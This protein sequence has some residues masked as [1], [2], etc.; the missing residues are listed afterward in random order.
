MTKLLLSIPTQLCCDLFLVDDGAPSGPETTA[1]SSETNL[2]L[3]RVNH[4]PSTGI[5]NDCRALLILELLCIFPDS[6]SSKIPLY[7]DN[8][9]TTM[10]FIQAKAECSLSPIL[11]NNCICPIGDNISPLNPIKGV[12]A[13]KYYVL[14]EMRVDECCNN[15]NEGIRR[16]VIKTY[17]RVSRQRRVKH[18]AP[19]WHG[20]SFCFCC[21]LEDFQMILRIFT[22]VICLDMAGHPCFLG[23]RSVKDLLPHIPMAGTSH[24]LPYAISSSLILTSSALVKVRW[25]SRRGPEFTWER[26]DSFKQ[27]YPQLFTNWASSSTTRS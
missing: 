6:W 16:K 2:L 15:R 7:I 1:H 26:E 18:V 3:F 17:S 8:D 11:T 22:V 4:T 21:C 25:N 19:C 10:K 13:V 9:L 14:G 24:P 12:V 20:L 23:S 5:F 27:K